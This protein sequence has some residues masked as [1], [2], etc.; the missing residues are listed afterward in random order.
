MASPCCLAERVCAFQSDQCPSYSVQHV[1]RVPFRWRC[2][3]PRP[4]ITVQH[5][6]VRRVAPL[7]QHVL[8]SDV[9]Q[10]CVTTLEGFRAAIRLVRRPG[11]GGCVHVER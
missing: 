5:P 10:S 1:N 8:Q 6:A 9:L 4:G 3:R 2:L 7:A 11:L